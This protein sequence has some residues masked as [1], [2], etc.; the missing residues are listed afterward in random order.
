[1]YYK[2]SFIQAHFIFMISACMIALGIENAAI[3]CII[4]IIH[5]ELDEELYLL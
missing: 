4:C 5:I 3:M 1:M 2:Q